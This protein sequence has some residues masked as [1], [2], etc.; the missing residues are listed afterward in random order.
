[1]SR[2][3]SY[4]LEAFTPDVSECR[5]SK[6]IQNHLVIAVLVKRNKVIASST[7]RA[8]SRSMGS[9]YSDHTIHAERA[10][11]KKL[12]DITKLK[13][14]TMYVWRV[15]TRQ[16]GLMSKPCHDCE[17]FLEKCMKQYGLRGVYYTQ[18]SSAPECSH[19]CSKS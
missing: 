4:L 5:Q 1:M 8:G 6:R 13:G 17:L 10:V 14:C 3:E 9:G 11:V 2:L 7:N 12:G 19:C 16:V 18:N 15:T